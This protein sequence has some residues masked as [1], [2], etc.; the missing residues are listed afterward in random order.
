MKAAFRAT[1]IS[2]AALLP[3]MASGQEGWSSDGRGTSS[4]H[5]SPSPGQCNVSQ[6]RNLAR[7]ARIYRTDVVYQDENVV[8][9]RGMT[10]GGDRREISFANVR[11]CPEVGFNDVVPGAVDTLGNPLGRKVPR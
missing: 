9:L 1:L 3:T 10:D 4:W 5:V 2:F 6:A 11:G 7:R 8:T